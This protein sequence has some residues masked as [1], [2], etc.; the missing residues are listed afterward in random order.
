MKK[1]SDLDYMR[2]SIEEMH[3]SIQ[4]SRNDDK[5]SPKVGAVLVRNDG[6]FVAAHRGELREGDHAEY[7]LLERKCTAENVTGTVVFTTLE[8]CC[9]RHL[10]KVSCSQRLIEARV[11][12]VYIGIEDPDPTVSGQG[13]QRLIDAG[14]EVAMYPP[15]LQQEIEEANKDFLKGA[16][17]RRL[18]QKTGKEQPLLSAV[19]HTSLDM[20]QTKTVNTFLRRVGVTGID[21]QEGKSALLQ[22]QMI[23][24]IKDGFAP[25]QW[26]LLLFG[27]QPQ[28]SFPN[29]VIRATYRIGQQE[30]D[31][32]VIDGPLVLQSEKLYAWYKDKLKSHIDRSEPTRKKIYDVPTEVISE[33]V[34][35]AIVHRDYSLSGAPIYFEINDDNLIIKS[36]GKPV[37][38]ITLAQI[39][40]FNAPSLSRNPLVMFAFEKL[41]LAEQRGLGFGTIRNMPIAQRPIVSFDDPYIVFTLPLVEKSISD[42]LSQE[43]TAQFIEGNESFTRKQFEEYFGLSSKEANR[44]INKLIECGLVKMS[45]SKRGAIY[46]KVK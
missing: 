22:L 30:I 13:K 39:Q 12:K 40:T 28:L 43:A 42:R 4:E 32:P 1:M 38:P 2:L 20:L 9:E 23:S 35:N 36:P 17:K 29:A 19:P 10:P 21:T 16:F 14:I 24:R 3:K 6:S 27:K 25:T 41:D 34:K 45:G 15:E 44:Q 5:V 18:E 26:G 11:K 7:T 31:L 8:P 46:L 33:L 37:E